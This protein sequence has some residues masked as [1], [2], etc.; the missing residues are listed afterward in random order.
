VKNAYPFKQEQELVCEVFARRQDLM[1]ILGAIL[2]ADLHQ[3]QGT[4][5]LERVL[6]LEVLKQQVCDYLGPKP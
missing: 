1:I 2:R 6:I 4:L 3:V 5:D